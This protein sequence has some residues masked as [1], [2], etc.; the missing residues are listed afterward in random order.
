[1]SYYQQL[2]S[3]EQTNHDSTLI[4]QL[5]PKLISE[6]QNNSLL[7]VP[8]EAEIKT[9]IQ[10]MNSEGAVG[11]DGYGGIFYLS[12]WE[13]IKT[14]LIHAVQ[15]FF[16]EHSPPLSWTS[17]LIVMVSKVSLLLILKS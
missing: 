1:M 4:P 3:N 8:D 10:A 2:F 7:Q 15:D 6:V 17:T 12:C 11:P 16:R 5:I 13:I 9:A 14:D